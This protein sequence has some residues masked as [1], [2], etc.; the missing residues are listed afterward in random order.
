MKVQDVLRPVSRDQ[1]KILSRQDL[2]DLFLGEQEIWRQAQRFAQVLEEE[3]YLIGEKYVHIK[4]RLFM[5]SSEKTPKPEPKPKRPGSGSGKKAPDDRTRQPSKRYPHAP[6]I[7][8]DVTI[9]PPPACATCGT[10]TVDSGLTEVSESIS[11]IPKKFIIKRQIYHKYCCKTCQGHLETA[12]L[13]PRIK[14]GSSYDDDLIIDVAMSKYCDLIPIER[15]VAMAKR[16]GFPGLPP[17]SL[18]ELTHY[19]AKFLTPVYDLVRQEVLS[20]LVLHADETPHR[21]LEGSDKSTWSLWGFSTTT[22]SYFECHATRSGDVAS[23]LL[24]KSQCQFLVS[25]VYSGYNKAVKECNVARLAAGRNLVLHVYCNAHARRKFREISGDDGTF[26]V[27]RYQEIYALEKEAQ[28]LDPNGRLAKRQEMRP[29]FEQIRVRA[30]ELLDTVSS[31]GGTATAINYFLKNFEALTR[32]LDN[33]LLP[34]DNNHQ[35]RQLRNHVIGRKTW[36]GTHS[37]RGAQTATI[38]FSIVE[39]CKLNNIN[40]REYIQQVVRDIHQKKFP[41]SPA[42]AAAAQTR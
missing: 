8:Q 25:D 23:D 27:E 1:L 37:Q 32:F 40:P 16:Q 34:I 12:P 3:K 7:E 4:N 33:P 2:V 36:Y 5:P 11:V 10:E 22:A 31:R 29:H 21:M 20:T 19:L 17:H 26:F 39:S 14:P 9:V 15:Y 18:I 35:E 42:Q 30:T 13:L 38:L 41:L 28:T 6:V 24:I